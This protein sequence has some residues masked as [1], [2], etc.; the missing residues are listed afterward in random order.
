MTYL[1]SCFFFFNQKAC[2]IPRQEI[3]RITTVFS[4]RT[5]RNLVVLWYNGICL[6]KHKCDPDPDMVTASKK[7]CRSH[8]WF[9]VCHTKLH[10]E[11]NTP[12]LQRCTSR[13]MAQLNGFFSS[14]ERQNIHEDWYLLALGYFVRITCLNVPAKKCPCIVDVQ[15]NIY[16]MTY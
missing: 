3:R 14:S 4:G 5:L 1:H 2:Y 16:W 11:A 8:H 7:Q 13:V 15:L 12:A 9:S 10:V 6:S